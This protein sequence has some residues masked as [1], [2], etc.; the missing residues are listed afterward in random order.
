[1]KILVIGHPYIV[2]INRLKWK[3]L[4]QKYQDLDLK[5]IVPKFWLSSLFEHK[6]GDLLKENL[7]NCEFISLDTR[8]TG[9]EI[10]YTYKF[11]DLFRI[12]KN[13]KPDLMHVE[14]GSNALSFLQ[15]ILLSKLLRFK[16][17]FSF[18]TWVNW[19]I[20]K[21]LKYKLTLGL[22]EKFNLRNSAGVIVGNSQAGEILKKNGFNK[23]VLELLQLGVDEEIFCSHPFDFALK[24]LRSGRTGVEFYIVRGERNEVKSNPYE[25]QYT[26]GFIGRI[27]PEKGVFLLAQA[28]LEIYKKYP[29]WELVFVGDGPA[30]KDLINFINKNNLENKIFILNSMPHEEIANIIKSFDILV[31][32]SYDT[33][34]WKEQ[35]GHV[36]IEAMACK[37]PVIGSTAGYISQVIGK[38]GLIFEQNNLKGLIN[39]LENLILNSKLRRE[40]GELGYKRFKENY[41]Y[42]NI[43]KKTYNFWKS[44]I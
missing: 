19:E 29:E 43:S 41:S 11:K 44:L 26:I 34:K 16:T 7:N 22:V 9:N 8:K 31:L 28:F 1:M 6:A 42:D 35:F 5:I 38:S 18:F 14:Q 27:V 2:K 4:A 23:N 37:I 30:K 13:F 15:V 12:L 36:L 40:L 25:R 24:G 20:K 10:L 17:K 21:S 33:S 32:P 3:I 39:S